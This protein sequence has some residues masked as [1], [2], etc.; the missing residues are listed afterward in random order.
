LSEVLAL[1]ASN[2]PDENELDREVGGEYNTLRTYIYM[3]RAKICSARDLQRA[4][5]LSSPTLAQH[6]LEK[7]RRFGLVVKDDGTYRVVPKS[8]GVL[9]LYIRSGRWIVPRTIFFAIIFGILGT[10]SA[11][12]IPQNPSFAIIS[13][14]SFAGLGYALYETMR[15]YKILPRT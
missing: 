5:G 9:K 6:H 14:I 8:F 13:I 2:K 1:L 15:F 4:L 12:S 10:G 3:L 11:V 7:L